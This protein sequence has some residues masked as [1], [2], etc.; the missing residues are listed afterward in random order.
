[1]SIQTQ[2]DEL[3]LGQTTNLSL[4]DSLQPKKAEAN[5]RGHHWFSREITSE[6]RPQKVI[7][8]TCHY[9]DL[10][11]ASDWLKICLIQSEPCAPQL[12]LVY[13]ANQT[14][15]T[16]LSAGKCVQQSSFTRFTPD[17]LTKWRENISPITRRSKQDRPFMVNASCGSQQL[18]SRPFA[19]VDHGI[20]FR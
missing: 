19:L 20:N 4:T 11:I 16:N 5:S 10:D 18:N 6:K 15:K 3:N 2:S 1:M 17:L 8:M 13:V 7:L 9:P 14:N 12:R